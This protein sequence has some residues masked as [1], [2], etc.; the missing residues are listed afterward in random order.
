M[1]EL[2]YINYDL[3][4]PVVFLPTMQHRRMDEIVSQ[5]NP[6]DV[7]LTAGFVRLINNRFHVYGESES[8]GLK[9]D[10]QDAELL[11]MW[12]ERKRMDDFT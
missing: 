6:G 4:G 8:L 3:L 1:L 12:Y 5:G 2:K 7:P 9:S 11:N 10:S